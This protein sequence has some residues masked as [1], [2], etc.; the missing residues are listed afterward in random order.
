MSQEEL[1]RRVHE[2]LSG[3]E[4]VGPFSAGYPVNQKFDYS[5]LYPLLAFAA[6]NVGDPFGYSRYQANTHE[7]E[8]EVA[9]VKKSYAARTFA[10]AADPGAK[11]GPNAGETPRA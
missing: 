10:P 9:L 8:R 4:L 5:A 2:V 6:N 7:I 1:D 3:F 11:V